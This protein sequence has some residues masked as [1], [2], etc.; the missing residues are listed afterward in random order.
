MFLENFEAP[1]DWAAI[2]NF[3]QRK[4]ETNFL[5]TPV[6]LKCKIRSEIDCVESSFFKESARYI[7][8]GKGRLNDDVKYGDILKLI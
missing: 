2:L 8:L 3:G 4:M 6:Y 1:S 5:R 7:F